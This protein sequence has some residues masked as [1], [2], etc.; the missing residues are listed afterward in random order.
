MTAAMTGIEARMKTGTG[1]E[2]V[3]VGRSERKNPGS[4]MQMLVNEEIMKAVYEVAEML[5]SGALHCSAKIFVC[6]L[7]C[8]SIN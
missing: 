2:G 8:C 3:E 5:S 4:E 1:K 6:K 7:W